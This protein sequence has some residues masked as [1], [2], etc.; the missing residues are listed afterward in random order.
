MKTPPGNGISRLFVLDSEASWIRSLL[1]AMPLG[2]RIHGFR[3]RNAFSFPGGLRG[4][5]Q[6]VGRS[7]RVSGTWD[8]IS[9]SVPSWHR[10]FAL[11][12]WL[13]ARQIRKTIRCCGKPDA[14]LFTLPWYAKVAEQMDC[15]AKAYYAHDTFRFYGWDRKKTIAL[16]GRLLRGCN[17][18]FGVAKRV[19]TDLHQLAETPVCYLPMATAWSPG[20]TCPE[21]EAAAEEDLESVRKPRVGC[22]GQIHS[23]AYDWE[24]IEHLSASFPHVHFVFIGPRFKEQ[25][26]AATNPIEA[27]FAHPN[28]HWLGPKPH[29]HLPAYLRRF[30]V[31]INPLCLSEHNHRRSPL[32]LFDYLTTERPIVSTAIA[33]AF[34]HAPFVSIG[35]DKE[36]F[37]RLLGAALSL[38]EAPNLE[39]R[40]EYIAAN[41][42][43]SRA[44]ELY[45][46]V[47]GA[48]S[49]AADGHTRSIAQPPMS[50]GHFSSE[51]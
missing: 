40:R 12:S 49:Q 26:R 24:L 21:G 19:M 46:Q 33:E 48:N 2:V 18:G 30:N 9:V 32:R 10:A 7:E 39:A 31:C 5:F 27:V 38:K 23:S 1:H 37:G 34:N 25:S 15:P 43:H 28:V 36:D 20:Q 13:V 8:D 44:V 16:E 35:K 22:V 45:T 3:I 14:V 6:K 29:A 42:W 50:H 11:S 17:V 4:Q 47:N 41:T 51:A